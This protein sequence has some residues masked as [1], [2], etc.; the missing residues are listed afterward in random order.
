MSC[1]KLFEWTIFN[2]A[3]IKSR[4]RWIACGGIGSQS[5]SPSSV[6]TLRSPHCLQSYVR[7]AS[8]VDVMMLLMAVT[9]QHPALISKLVPCGF[10]VSFSSSSLVLMGHVRSTREANKTNSSLPVALAMAGGW[11]RMN[12]GLCFSRQWRGRTEHRFRAECCVEW[13][14]VVCFCVLSKARKIG[15]N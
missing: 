10:G 1:K 15:E 2:I 11:Q 7:V 8:V 4:S 12:K 14:C 3:N 13:W 9:V 6:T 5:A